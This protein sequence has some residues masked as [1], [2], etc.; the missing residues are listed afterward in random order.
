MKRCSP[1]P[2]RLAFYRAACPFQTVFAT[3][4]KNHKSVILFKSY[5]P[6]TV[7]FQSFNSGLRYKTKKKKKVFI[8]Q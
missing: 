1:D 4:Y 3:E 6:G 5:R 8:G 7:G 2:S